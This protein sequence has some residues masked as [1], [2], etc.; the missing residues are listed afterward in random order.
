[1]TTTKAK[2]REQGRQTINNLNRKIDTPTLGYVAF[3][4]IRPPWR[5]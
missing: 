1:M 2:R 3:V 5:S 4:G